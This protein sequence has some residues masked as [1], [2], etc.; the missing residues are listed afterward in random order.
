MDRPARAHAVEEYYRATETS[1]VRALERRGYR[2]DEIGTH[3]A[4]A[5]TS[6][7]LA[8]DP[9]LVR[10]DLL[11]SDVKF[12]RAE[13]VYGGDPRRASAELGQLGVDSIVAETV[14]AI[15]RDIERRR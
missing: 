15:R 13:G 2:D 8:I 4:L 12:G 11:R 1:Y 9:S 7:T 5:D 6:L 10:M 3:A 14:A